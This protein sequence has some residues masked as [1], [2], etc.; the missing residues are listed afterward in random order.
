MTKDEFESL[1]KAIKHDVMR[2]A[3]THCFGGVGICH[4]DKEEYHAWL[5]AFRS[6]WVSISL[7]QDI[8]ELD[9]QSNQSNGAY[10]ATALGDPDGFKRMME[11]LFD[12]CDGYWREVI[13]GGERTASWPNQAVEAGDHGP[14]ISNSRFKASNKKRER[15]RNSKPSNSEKAQ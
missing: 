11:G 5:H 13:R 9:I 6:V 10:F 3:N 8:L 1:F 4:P 2:Y 12:E 15:T 14:K 7:T